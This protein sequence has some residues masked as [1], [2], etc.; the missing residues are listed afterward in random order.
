MTA[1]NGGGRHGRCRPAA[2]FNEAA[3]DDRGK[4]PS[5]PRADSSAGR[6]NEAAADDRGKRRGRGRLEAERRAASMRPRPMT[7]ENISTREPGRFVS[8]ALQ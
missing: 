4:H 3:A 2:R 6:F 7:A 8:G 1:E 5:R